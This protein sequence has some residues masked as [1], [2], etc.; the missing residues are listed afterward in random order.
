MPITGS[1]FVQVVVGADSIVEIQNETSMGMIGYAKCM[2]NGMP[3]IKYQKSIM[4]LIC[5]DWI[6]GLKTR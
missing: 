3:S 4:N 1:L 5:N 2:A 6:L